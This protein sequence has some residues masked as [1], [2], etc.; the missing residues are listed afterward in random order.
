[1]L[2]LALA[3]MIFCL[4]TAKAIAIPD[5]RGAQWP[6]E[7]C[8]SA[9]AAAERGHRVPP[10]L[11][12]AIGRV[13]SGKRDPG[14]GAWDAWP[15]TINAEG[16]GA[17]FETKADAIKAVLAL[18]ANGV[19]SIDVGCM[20][21]N[22]M[23]HPDAF[24]NL[25]QAFE[26]TVNADYAARFLLQLYGQSGD[27]NKSTASYH[28]AN[29]WEGEPYAAK[30]N[31]V[32]PEEQR[33]AGL[34]PPLP[35][36][37]MVPGAMNRSLPFARMEGRFPVRQPPPMFPLAGMM[38]GT[39]S[40]GLSPGTVPPEGI[41]ATGFMRATS[42]MPAMPPL[43]RIMPEGMMMA[44]GTQGGQ[45]MPPGMMQ[46]G[47]APAGHALSFYRSAP[48]PAGTAPRMIVHLPYRLS[49]R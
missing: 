35:F 46:A 36:A 40:G 16:Q 30:V 19:R 14:T 10:Q 43:P 29:P 47:V 15:W 45:L 11:L 8:R 4:L 7:Q 41:V 1:M 22:L 20:Q 33:K 5:L 13:E 6:G 25:D 39:R 24:A 23:H 31:S 44:G 2:R 21:V 26:P 27:W 28:S 32:W 37:G 12:A 17:W 34:V 3:T 49:L 9:I 48:V 42:P 38:P 18:Q